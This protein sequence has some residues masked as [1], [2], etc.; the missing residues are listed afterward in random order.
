VQLSLPAG[1]RG[2][3][4]DL[5]AAVE[6]LPVNV[7]QPARVVVDEA[8]GTVVMGSDVRIS[9][10][11]IAQ[12]HL[13]IRVSEAPQVSQPSPFAEVGETAVVPR[14]RVDVDDGDGKRLRVVDGSVSLQ[15]MVNGLNALGVSPRDL[16]AILQSLKAAGALQA[17]VVVF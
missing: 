5:V 2:S 9:R 11:A 15:D 7:D 12:G 14:T 8:S 4:I 16:I 6:R 3:M 1:Y 10:V 13:T 17:D